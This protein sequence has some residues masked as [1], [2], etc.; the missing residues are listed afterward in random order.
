MVEILQPPSVL[1]EGMAGSYLPIAIAHG[2][3]RAEFRA[4][5]VAE[6]LYEERAAWRTVTSI[7]T[8]RS[9]TSTYPANPNGSPRGDRGADD[10]GRPRHR[11]RCRIPSAYSARSRTLGTRRR[12]ARMRVGCA[13]S[14]TRA[15]GWDEIRWVNNNDNTI[16]A[17]SNSMRPPAPP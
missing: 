6:A 13:C 9:R 8:A 10:T 14:A 2:E 17:T 5:A 15:S 3:G 7:T 16:P 1:L 4:E 11:S 12:R